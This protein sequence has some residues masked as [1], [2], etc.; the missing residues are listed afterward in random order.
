MENFKIQVALIEE[1]NLKEKLHQKRCL[2]LYRALLRQCGV[3]DANDQHAIA[4]NES[5][6]KPIIEGKDT[7]LILLA[8]ECIGLI[9]LIHKEAW[10]TYSDVF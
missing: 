6:I 2:I 9:C 1:I 8:I 3:T 4:L 5:L 7:E 10:Y